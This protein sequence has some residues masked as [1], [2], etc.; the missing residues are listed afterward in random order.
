MKR[1]L[2]FFNFHDYKMTTRSKSISGI[3]K[4]YYKCRKCSKKIKVEYASTGYK[5]NKNGTK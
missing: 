1:L 2:C 3:I 5:V 4:N